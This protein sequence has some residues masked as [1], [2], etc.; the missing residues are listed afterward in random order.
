MARSKS[1]ASDSFSTALR[2]L[3]GR[4]RTEAELSEKLRQLGF[5]VSEI[6]ETLAKCRDYNY[7]N[8]Q[9]YALE[10][11]RALYRSGR[12]VGRKVL[13]DL[14]RRG[15]DEV[16]AEQALEEVNSEFESLQLLREQLA[17]RFPNFS[18]QNADERQRRRVVSFF[19]RRGFILG[20][21]F[22]VLKTDPDR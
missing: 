8:D 3:T 4:D 17:R 16:T 1:N 7:V 18:Y 9:K 5:S 10:R 21:I 19:Q 6:S 14:R 11:A 22:S 12:A 13:L 15:I 2:L 20:D